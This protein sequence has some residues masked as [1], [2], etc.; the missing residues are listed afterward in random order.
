MGLT[1]GLKLGSRLRLE[2]GVRLTGRV[3]AI[4]QHLLEGW[5]RLRMLACHSMSWV[6]RT[7][8]GHVQVY[9]RLLHC[10]SPLP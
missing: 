4:S 7:L 10:V 2:D 3:V 5:L 8:P 9:A 6:W 1:V